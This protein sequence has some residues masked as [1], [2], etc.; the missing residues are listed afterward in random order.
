MQQMKKWL[1]LVAATVTMAALTASPAQAQMFWQAPD[2]T[3][4]PIVEGEP[5][6]G[7]LLPGAKPAEVQANY[8]WQLRAALNVMALQCQF[9]RTLM[10]QNLYN[11]ILVNHKEELAR[12]YTTL[13]GYFT[14][15]N[16]TPKAARNA[17]DQYGTKT[18]LGFSTV[19]AQIGF[20]QASSNVA[21]SA[22]F[23]PRGAFGK[24]AIERLREVRN[25]LVPAGEQ[26]FRFP[27]RDF[28]MRLPDMAD[29][30]W[31]KRGNYT[32]VC[33]YI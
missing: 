30:C 10:A 12:A 3:G 2:F 15:M 20:C 25:S 28:S 17:L 8:T 18:Y 24:V 26:Y 33:P 11:G 21:R 13:T 4:A 1:P 31:D 6:I 5:G 22:L 32:R 29:R 19:R 7:L 16:K 27:R 14:R 9:E 23:A